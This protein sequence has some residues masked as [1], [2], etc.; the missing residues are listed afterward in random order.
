MRSRPQLEARTARHTV[1]DMLAR[2]VARF[3]D[4]YTPHGVR[5]GAAAAARTLFYE[6]LVV[7]KSRHHYEAA[8]NVNIHASGYPNRIPT[9]PGTFSTFY[10]KKAIKDPVSE[11][12]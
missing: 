8:E 4:C 5:A 7:P 9:V 6:R 1:P 12:P 2:C 11:K 3:V 10:A